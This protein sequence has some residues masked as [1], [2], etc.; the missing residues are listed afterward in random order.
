MKIIELRSDTV[1]KPTPAMW[2]AMA[3]AE[4]GDDQY[5]EDPTVRRLEEHAANLLGK[6]AA[7]YVASGTMG[8]L[9]AVLSHCG[10][11]DEAILGDESHIFMY[12]SCGAAALGG[13]PFSLRRTG[14]LG[15]LDLDDV[16]SAIRPVRAGYPRTGL[17]CIEN[18]HNRC[19]GTV[20][21]PSYPR[22]LA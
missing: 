14:R 2:R 10:R 8:N 7:V 22:E 4:V 16:A 6:E 20:L 12:E 17:V 19:G 3:E 9:V 15:E 13:I 5:G 18:T 11:G 1:T 21:P